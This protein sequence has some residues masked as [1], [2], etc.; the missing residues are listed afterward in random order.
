MATPVHRFPSF[1]GLSQ[2]SAARGF[3]PECRAGRWD[4]FL[5]SRHAALLT[6]GSLIALT[7]TLF[8]LLWF[9]PFWLA[10]VPGVLFVHRMGVLLH[11]YLH[12]IPFRRYRDN[13]AVYGFFDGLMLMFNLN[14]HVHHHE[15]VR[16][17]WY[18]LK[19]RTPQPLSPRHYYTHWFR[20]YVKHSCVLMHPMPAGNGNR[21]PLSKS[22][23]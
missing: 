15:D 7:A 1:D 17:P 20:V 6:H 2:P 22:P 18:L 3:D 4:R 16:C 11:E 10:F 14:R 8:G 12:G 21:N 23:S 5:G 9:I 19:F 13:L